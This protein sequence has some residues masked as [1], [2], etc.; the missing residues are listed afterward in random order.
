M[1]R[2][3]L[4]LLF[5]LALT[6]CAQTHNFVFL[7]Q[8]ALDQGTGVVWAKHA[9]L[10]GKQLYWKADDNVYAFIQKLNNENYAGYADWRVPTKS[11]MVELIAYAKSRGYDSAKFE[12]WPYK[13]LRQLGFLEV[14]DYDYWT[15][16]RKSSEELWVADL[17][18]GQVVPKSDAKAYY[19]WPVRGGRAR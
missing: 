11:E 2:K 19:L 14:R 9:N 4:V 15:S 12:T 1:M 18:S 6:S 5:C 13:Q 3:I 16:T 8:T 7:D 17:A 10:A